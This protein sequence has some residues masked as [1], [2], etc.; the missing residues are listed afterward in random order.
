MMASRE[1]ARGQGDTL[2]R[3]T[4]IHA[5]GPEARRLRGLVAQRAVTFRVAGGGPRWRVAGRDRLQVS[6]LS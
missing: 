1:G 5:R 2:T 6:G 4:A 3:D